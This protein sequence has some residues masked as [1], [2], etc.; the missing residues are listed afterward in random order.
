[1]AECGL[2]LADDGAPAAESRP[3]PAERGLVFS[4]QSGQRGAGGGLVSAALVDRAEFS[5]YEKPL[6]VGLDAS[7]AGRA[8]G[9]L[10]GGVDADVGLAELGGVARSTRQASG[11]ECR[12]G[13]M[14][15]GQRDQT[16]V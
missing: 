10:G 16:R 12:G 1:M 9:A 14:G 13:A 15:A 2:L 5:G 3:S 4:D 6:W 11:V 7:G 8:V